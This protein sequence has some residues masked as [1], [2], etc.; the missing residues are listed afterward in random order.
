MQPDRD[1]VANAKIGEVDTAYVQGFE[2][3]FE[4][5]ITRGEG[6]GDRLETELV[7]FPVVWCVVEDPRLCS[8]MVPRCNEQFE[9]RCWLS[10]LGDLLG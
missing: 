9:F 10:H 1:R 8:T 2:T 7:N 5:V 6:E 4:T 3:W